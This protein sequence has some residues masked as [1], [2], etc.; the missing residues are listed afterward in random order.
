MVVDL[1]GFLLYN[2][3]AVDS[4]KK[5]VAGNAIYVAEDKA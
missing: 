1:R 3:V 4:S 5:R 2:R